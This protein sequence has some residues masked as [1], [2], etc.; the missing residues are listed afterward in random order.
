[1]AARWFLDRG[2]VVSVP[3]QPACYHMITD[4]DD[5]LKKDPGQDDPSGR[6]QWQVRRE[7]RQDDLRSECDGKLPQ[8]STGRFP[9]ARGWWIAS[10]P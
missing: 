7:G 5:G 4:S 3:L 6:T 9:M 8:A 2:Y 10:L 1:M